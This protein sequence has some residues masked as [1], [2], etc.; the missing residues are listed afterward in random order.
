MS[1]RRGSLSPMLRLPRA[2]VCAFGLA[3][4]LVAAVGPPASE[5]PAEAASHEDRPNGSIWVSTP[6]VAGATTWEWTHTNLWRCDEAVCN[7]GGIGAGR[8]GGTESTSCNPRAATAG[9]AYSAGCGGHN[10]GNSGWVFT[11]HDNANTGSK[12]D[13]SALYSWP[14][15]W[16][17]S[18]LG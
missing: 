8:R 14:R 2:A 1:H 10:P 16:L 17:R 5:R 9:A 6:V 4:A 7:G 13:G 12:V 3:A 18:A 11:G 15:G